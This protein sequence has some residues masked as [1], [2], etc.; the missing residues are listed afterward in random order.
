MFVSYIA[1]DRVILQSGI[2]GM[3]YCR[4]GGGFWRGGKMC[5][6]TTPDFDGDDESGER[7]DYY[8]VQGRS[9]NQ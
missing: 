7:G 5:V 2:L 4:D 9:G 8:M 3:G 6:Y 1:Q